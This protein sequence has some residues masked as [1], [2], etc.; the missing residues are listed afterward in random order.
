MVRSGAEASHGDPPD[1]LRTSDVTRDLESWLLE[2]A[3][4]YVDSWSGY[5][6]A[7]RRGGSVLAERSLG[8]VHIYLDQ[9]AWIALL[10]AKEGR[11]D[12]ARYEP[13]L[14]LLKEAVT[15]GNVSLPLSSIHYIETAR[16]R[17]FA[18][19]QPLARLMAE[20]SKGHCIAPFVTLARA[21]IRHAVARTFGSRIVPAEPRPFGRGADHAFDMDFIGVYAERAV[22]PTRLV[23]SLLE[24]VAIA[25]DPAQDKMERSP[26]DVLHA[27]M[28][29]QAEH[30]EHSART[31]AGP[32]VNDQIVFG[33][34]S[35]TAKRL[36]N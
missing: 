1:S 12:G 25:G 16:R 28:Q 10:K 8:D 20:L 34:Q 15:V 7:P 24:W 30:F 3:E 31:K 6:E 2:R 36:R 22:P 23:S 18:K 4:S 14:L 19:R 5:L 29:A 9:C 35:P 32:G 13:L 27:Q 11:P 17:P 21:E 26:I 33:R